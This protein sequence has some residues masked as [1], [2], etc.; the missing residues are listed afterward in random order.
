MEED[1]PFI[2]V[3]QHAW[4]LVVPIVSQPIRTLVFAIV[5]IAEADAVRSAIVQGVCPMVSALLPTP[6]R[7]LLLLTRNSE[8]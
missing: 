2:P 5:L 8:S 6:T 4:W 3:N 7:L 1:V